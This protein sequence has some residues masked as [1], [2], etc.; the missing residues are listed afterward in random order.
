MTTPSPTD[1]GARVPLLASQHGMLAGQL[2]QPDNPAYTVAHAIF[3]RGSG[4]TPQA[5]MQALP[6]HHT[7]DHCANFHAEQDPATGHWWNVPVPERLRHDVS[8]V[9][10]SR[11]ADPVAATRELALRQALQPLGVLGPGPGRRDCIVKLADPTGGPSADELASIAGLRVSTPDELYG[12]GT[13][14]HGAGLSGAARPVV[15][16]D[17]PVAYSPHAPSY[18][19]ITA[20]H[21]ML[22]DGYGATVM[23]MKVVE[24]VAAASAGRPLPS[25]TTGSFRAL[26]EAAVQPAEEDL[27]FWTE[28]MEGAPLRQ[29]FADRPAPPAP[30]YHH[31]AVPLPG[32]RSQWAASAGGSGGSSDGS[33]G[34]PPG[35]QPTNRPSSWAHAAAAGAASYVSA[36]VDTPDVVVGFPVVGRSTPIEKAT[37]SQSMSVLPLRVRVDA[38]ASSTET[39]S[40]FLATVQET[41][42]HQKI[43]GDYLRARLPIAFRTG[44]IYGPIVNVIPYHGALDGGH[45]R[46]S[47]DIIAYGPIEDIAFLVVPGADEGVSVE[48]LANPA[49]YSAAEAHRHAERLARWLGQVAATPGEPITQLVALT[50][51]EE[52]AHRALARCGAAGADGRVLGDADC[53]RACTPGD[54]VRTALGHQAHVAGLALRTELGR[55][56]IF[57]AAGEVVLLDREGTETRTGLLAAL[58]PVTEAPG[59]AVEAPAR[60]TA[61]ATGDQPDLD[62]APR[63]DRAAHPATALVFHG[64]SDERV[65]IAGI[66]VELGGLRRLLD[67]AQPGLGAASTLQVSARRLSVTLPADTP[68][69]VRTRVTRDVKGYSR[70]A[71][72]LR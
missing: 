4:L 12:A 6:Q 26:A 55:S 18:A 41:K 31:A 51:Q 36:L 71:I 5:I 39:T 64:R 32:F 7:G 17:Q 59:E 34:T 49:L 45:L 46:V 65:E 42:P 53:G 67:A 9:D 48:V 20:F 54:L 68:E 10:L 72:K 30:R 61:P 2:Q 62:A 58:V 29:G 40:S 43:P 14:A 56:T 33:G 35:T 1:P 38:H 60:E 23:R 50:A 25:P 24:L 8:Y 57:G 16:A 21:H 28:H 44:R 63:P 47:Y 70:A 27:R 22:M 3:F 13:P 52:R 19:L 69:D 66:R 37:P 15:S 11:E